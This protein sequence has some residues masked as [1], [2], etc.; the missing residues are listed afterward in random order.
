MEASKLEHFAPGDQNWTK[1]NYFGL[2]LL[3]QWI[4]QLPIDNERQ[5]QRLCQLIPA[6][7]PF[8]R[9]LKIRG[10]TVLYLPPLCKLNP[11]YAEVAALRWRAL[12]YLVD[13]CD[14]D[15]SKYS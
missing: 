2:E 1:P 6:Q 4:N 8:E 15:I 13:E 3:R 12:C 11:V 5:A 10:K 9:Q 14:A 7:C